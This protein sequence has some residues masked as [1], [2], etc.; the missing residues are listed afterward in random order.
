VVE[1][2]VPPRGEPLPAVLRAQLSSEELESLLAGAP[3]AA[4]A[5]AETEDDPEAQEQERQPGEDG[6]EDETDEE[7]AGAAGGQDED[8]EDKDQ[9]DRN[10]DS[11]GNKTAAIPDGDV[12]QDVA[13]RREAEGDPAVERPQAPQP[14]QEAT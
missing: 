14:V 8:Q 1:L 10:Q 13:D 5:I 6:Q 11:Q 4:D 9:E 12:I 3:P 2:A 7:A